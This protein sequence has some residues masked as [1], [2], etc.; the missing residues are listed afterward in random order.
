MKRIIQL[1]CVAA[2]VL[3]VLCMPAM[4]DSIAPEFTEK[5]FPDE[6]ISSPEFYLDVEKDEN[7]NCLA[8]VLWLTHSEDMWEYMSARKLAFETDDIFKDYFHCIV[9]D[10]QVQ[11][12][13]KMDDGEWMYDAA[14]WDFCTEQDGLPFYLFNFRMTYTYNDAQTYRQDSKILNYSYAQDYLNEPDEEKRFVDLLIPAINYND[15]DCYALDLKNHTIT[16][17]VRYVLR[18]KNED[19]TEEEIEANGGTDVAYLYSDW[20]E[21]VSIGKNGT[22]VTPVKP[23]NMEAPSLYEFAFV[24]AT[25]DSDGLVTSN[26]RV[27]MEYPDSVLDTVKYYQLVEHTDAISV[28]M[29]YRIFKNGEWGEWKQDEYFDGGACWSGRKWFS[30]DGAKEGDPVEFRWFLQNN[31]DESME[32]LYTETLIANADKVQDYKPDGDDKSDEFGKPYTFINVVIDY[33]PGVKV[34]D[35]DVRIFSTKDPERKN[36]T[37]RTDEFNVQTNDAITVC[38]D[39]TI[40]FFKT[41]FEKED[42]V[43]YAY[44]N[45]DR[46]IYAVR[47][48]EDDVF[49]EGGTYGFFIGSLTAKDGSDLDTWSADVITFNGINCETAGGGY[50]NTGNDL[51]LYSYINNYKGT[52]EADPTPTPTPSAKPKDD[53]E[54]DD[55]EDE[56]DKDKC[57]L[58]GICPFQPLGICLF[59]W[60]AIIIVVAVAVV[61]IVKKLGKKDKEDKKQS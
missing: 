49:E 47:M 61:I 16:A 57:K 25:E 37:D 27:Y 14:T 39:M 28:V 9:E 17:R 35:V 34:K 1:L 55:D 60:I 12:D 4:A 29:E 53:E 30:I 21:E 32:K 23:E 31:E 19:M 54:E 8:V 46:G 3:V 51:M 41:V 42:G 56:E 52:E 59:V 24:D 11:T 48:S 33:K 58:C 40:R 20:T 43:E 38:G 50:G 36:L 26:W 10:I 22:Q 44:E 6:E 15:G 2:L 45:E 7:G 5:F 13:L 18:Y